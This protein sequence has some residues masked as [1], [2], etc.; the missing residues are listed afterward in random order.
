MGTAIVS[1]SDGWIAQVRWSDGGAGGIF[2]ASA[3]VMDPIYLVPE[4]EGCGNGLIVL[5]LAVA[6]DGGATNSDTLTLHVSNIN[7]LPRVDVPEDLETATGQRVSLSATAS[8][9]DGWIEEQ[10]WVQ[11]DGIDVDLWVESQ[12]QHVEF[13]A[14]DVDASSELVFRFTARDNCGTE[15]WNDVMVIVL[16]TAGFDGTPHHDTAR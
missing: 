6:D 1:D 9:E 7:E 16:P 14:P 10:H 12:G 4:I 5:T 11:V 15:V 3:D 2:L 13:D 8:D